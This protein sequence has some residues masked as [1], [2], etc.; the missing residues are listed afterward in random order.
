MHGTW[1]YTPTMQEF[2][3][4]LEALGRANQPLMQLAVRERM[5]LAGFEPTAET[6]SLLMLAYCRQGERLT[7]AHPW[8]GHLQAAIRLAHNMHEKTLVLERA[9]AVALRSRE[10][11]AIEEILA[12]VRHADLTAAAHGVL[13]MLLEGAGDV[14]AL[15]SVK[16]ALQQILMPL[17][18]AAMLAAFRLQAAVD[19]CELPGNPIRVIITWIK[20]E[21]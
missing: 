4:A 20:I 13:Q 2:H 11:A 21:Y 18:E 10:T 14:L 15:A 5:Q 1:K 3:L 17:S 7:R 8:F 19:P 6:H 9:L 12:W 16:V